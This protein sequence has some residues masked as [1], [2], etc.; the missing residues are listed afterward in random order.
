MALNP[1]VKENK[2]PILLEESDDNAKEKV[3]LVINDASFVVNPEP[4]N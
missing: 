3:M 4:S 1:H 2:D